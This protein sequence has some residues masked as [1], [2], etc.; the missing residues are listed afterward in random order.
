MRRRQ[1][2][3][4]FAQ[5][6]ELAQRVFGLLANAVGERE[7]DE[8]AREPGAAQSATEERA[9]HR[10]AEQIVH[11]E[12]LV[13]CLRQYAENVGAAAGTAGEGDTAPGD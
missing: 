11:N 8:T 5:R 4:F 1:A 13:A 2:D 6:D 3:E 12:R 9:A 10:L 7:D